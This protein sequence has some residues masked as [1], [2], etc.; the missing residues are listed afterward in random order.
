MSNVQIERCDKSPNTAPGSI[1]T[2]INKSDAIQKAKTK[3]NEKN[4]TDK[5]KN[6]LREDEKEL[7]LS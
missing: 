2:I 6:Q 7:K 1:Q 5:E 3:A 4:L